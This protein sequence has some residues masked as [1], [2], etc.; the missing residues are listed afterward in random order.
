MKKVILIFFTISLAFANFSVENYERQEKILKSIDVD[1]KYLNDESFVEIFSNMSERD[2]QYFTK[3]L[4]EDNMNIPIIKAILKKEGVPD[5]FLYLAMIE[6]NFKTHA[7]SGAKAVGVWQFMSPTAKSFGLKIDRYVDERKDVVAS[8]TAAARYLKRL[9][10]QFGKWYLAIFAY[11]C[12]DGCV[13]RAIANANS[14][15]LSVLLDENKKY[16]PLETRNFFRKIVGASLIAE[17]DIVKYGDA[18]LLN[19]IMSLNIKRVEIQANDNLVNLAK[20]A[21][22]SLSDLKKINP[23]F[24]TNLTPPYSYYIY[25]P[26]ER[27]ALFKNSKK[28]FDYAKNKVK[29]IITY[30]VKSGDTL[31]D[32]AKENNVTTKILK[33]F[34]NL[35]SD[36]LSVNQT[37][38]IPVL[39]IDESKEAKN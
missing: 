25:L 16:L 11:N 14:D 5:V 37:L 17:N 32:I 30:K 39:L 10:K 22:M 29:N 9:K 12:G 35:S 4:N 33:S 18:Y 27:V 6:S 2:I 8:S 21:G 31:Y 36:F 24:N 7:K 26:I 13:R 38:R 28:N 15:E 1:M 19:Q 20:R 3:I 23:H 34:N